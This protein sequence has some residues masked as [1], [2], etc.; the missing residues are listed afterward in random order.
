MRSVASTWR[1]SSMSMRTKFPRGRGVL[2]HLGDVALGELLVDRETEM[3]ELE[4]DVCPQ[5]LRL[6]AVEQLAV[7]GDDLARLGLVVDTLAE[8]R[9]VREKTLLVQPP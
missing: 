1:D 7:G 3:R 5:A 2:D 8:Q 6:N 4:R 9:R